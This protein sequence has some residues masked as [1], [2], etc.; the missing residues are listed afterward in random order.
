MVPGESHPST[1]QEAADQMRDY[2]ED[3]TQDAAEGYIDG[4]SGSEN[5]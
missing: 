4:E 1:A 3:Q 5:G 2:A